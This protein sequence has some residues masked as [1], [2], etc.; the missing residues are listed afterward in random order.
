M[1]AR[2]YATG[3]CKTQKEASAAAGLHP[4]Y[5]TLLMSE[6]R[7]VQDFVSRIDR[8]IE[9]DAVDMSKML[10]TLGR[11]GVRN[12]AQLMENGESEQ[13]RFKA[14]QDLADRSP[15]TSKIQKHAVASFSIEGED[16]KAIAAALV[17]SATVSRQF[18]E[19]GSGDFVRVDTNAAVGP[20]GIP[21]SSAPVPFEQSGVNPQPASTPAAH[22]PG[23]APQSVEN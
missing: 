10:V 19:V 15:E 9:S 23:E 11:R 21:G 13:V 17:E 14:A 6:N 2:L 18:A 8:E 12:I 7:M 1:A 4:N 16:A 20:L 3:A 5:L 22:A